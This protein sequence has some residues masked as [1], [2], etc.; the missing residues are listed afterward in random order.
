MR[1]PVRGIIGSQFNS[2]A[3]VL[4][5]GC[6]RGPITGNH[7]LEG[8]DEDDKQFVNTIHVGDVL[9]REYPISRRDPIS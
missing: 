1:L 6:E 2:G 8:I 9:E 3:L 5:A 4:S 7:G